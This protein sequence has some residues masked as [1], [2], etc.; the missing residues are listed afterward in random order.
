MYAL[1]SGVRSKRLPGLVHDRHRRYA[2]IYPRFART[3]HHPRYANRRVSFPLQKECV[4]GGVFGLTGHELDELQVVAERVLDRIR[5]REG[6]A[7]GADDLTAEAVDPRRGIVC[8][9]VLL[10]KAVA[11]AS[12]VGLHIVVQLLG[13]VRH[14]I[15][16]HVLAIIHEEQRLKVERQLV[17]RSLVGCGLSCHVKVI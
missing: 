4:D 11:V 7:I 10:Y 14:H 3:R 15:V 9:G 13:G 6:H 17:D 16:R 2:K 8:G 12:R 5:L 1:Y